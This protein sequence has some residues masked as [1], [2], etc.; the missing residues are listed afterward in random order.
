[1]ALA[2]WPPHRVALAFGYPAAVN[3]S[4]VYRRPRRLRRS[5]GAPAS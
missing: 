5:C 4:L 3:R 2:V 1:L